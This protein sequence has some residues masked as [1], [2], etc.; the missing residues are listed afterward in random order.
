M[1]LNTLSLHRDLTKL[2][3]AVV[4]VL[5]QASVK[6][7]V[8]VTKVRSLVLAVVFVQVLKVVKCH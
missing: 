6:L 5:V 8:V 2:K 4:V 7:V 1:H 3:S